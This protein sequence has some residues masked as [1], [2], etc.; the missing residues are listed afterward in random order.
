MATI[1]DVAKRAGVAPVTVSRVINN[2]PGV[3]LATR[4][5]VQ[6][7]IAELGYVPNVVARSLRSKRTR[8]LAF[9][10][11]DVTNPFWTTVARGV[12]DAA[13]DQ[14]YSVVLCNTDESASKQQRYIDLMVS[15]RVDGIIIAPADTDANRLATLRRHNIATVI[16]DR[17]IEGWEVDTVYSD[18][19]SGAY[20]LTRHLL[21]LGHTRIA[22]F[23][24]P[25]GA[26]TADDRIAGYWLALTEAN[27]TP[28]ARLIRRGGFNWEAGFELTNQV[29]DEGLAPTAIFAANNAIALGVID[30][31]GRRGLRIPR[32]IALVCFDDYPYV[33]G[34][35]PFLTVIAQPAYEMG[36]NAAQ[37][38]LSRLKSPVPLKPRRVV[39]PVR[40]IVRYSC[41]SKPNDNGPCP[42]NLPLEGLA[43]ERVALV[44][45]I[46]A[47]R[48]FPG[49]ASAVSL[50]G[51]IFRIVTTAVAPAAPQAA[52]ADRLRRA[53]RGE[54]TDR[55]PCVE[56]RIASRAVCEYVLEREV[57]LEGA[58]I[59]PEVQVELAQRASLDAVPCELP[60]QLPALADTSVRAPIPLAAQ[61]SHLERYLRAAQGTGVGVFASF[62]P[63]LIPALKGKG[64][65]AQD[66]L[67]A[68]ALQQLEPYLDAL[69]VQRARLL[70][71][72]CDRFWADL[73][74]VLI[75]EDIADRHGLIL[76]EHL[77]NEI[78]AP[79]LQRIIA[80]ALEHGLIT[81]LHSS[82]KIE[83]ALPTLR[84][85]GFDAVHG[86]APE[87]N[88]VVGLYH[89]WGGKLA[90]MGGIPDSLLT[91]GDADSL[92]A[93]VRELCAQI[94]HNG[95]F[96]L[97][98]SNGISEAVPP[99]NF[100]ALTAA[101]QRY[102]RPAAQTTE[103]D[104]LM[105]HVVN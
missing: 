39:L 25:E 84:A 55:I 21:G 20:A 99:Q 71:A 24:G 18:S 52:G 77:F 67:T 17:R 42:L 76:P 62:R 19:I 83:A 85:I 80:P 27:I 48:T 26:A 57:Q 97:G 47:G 92:D 68:G 56:L 37:L 12:E 31:V 73:A 58:A 8:T 86:M 29:L 30:A 96:V 51:T 11:P 94:G 46:P 79:R 41:G 98:S 101:A 22:M 9:V 45:P 103:H 23:S 34:F 70:R 49:P 82:G 93:A 91:K 105:A 50:E 90:F 14:G 16:I 44:K 28:D 5:R 65:R 64:H 78:L 104:F 4:E 102:G 81:V 13:Q 36:A 6:Q 2:A 72:A 95:G 66:A 59:P 53:L 87:H 7:A 35:F 63:A 89:R 3:N 60:N 100:A 54:P 75:H 1:T 74:F 38:L 15:Q 88:D 10:V 69:V 33:T 32:D 40:L 61:L 43:A